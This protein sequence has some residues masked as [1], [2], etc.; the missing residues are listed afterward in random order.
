[1]AAAIIVRARRGIPSSGVR[2]AGGVA[3][4]D[5]RW[6][7][8][9]LDGAPIVDDPIVP[10]SSTGSNEPSPRTP[11]RS[12][13]STGYVGSDLIGIGYLIGPEP[14]DVLERVSGA[15]GAEPAIPP[16]ASLSIWD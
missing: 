9:F 4:G 15:F 1:M 13:G 14:A 6:I 16:R 2:Y 11:P 7:D 8:S 12:N 3:S 10:A 5:S